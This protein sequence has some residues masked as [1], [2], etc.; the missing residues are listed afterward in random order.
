MLRRLLAAGTF[1]LVL[2]DAAARLELRFDVV[3]L[4]AVAAASTAS[5]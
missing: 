3:A 5:T 1:A 4:L 2:A